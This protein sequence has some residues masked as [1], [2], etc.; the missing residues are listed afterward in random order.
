M[1]ELN[2]LAD[3]IQTMRDHNAQGAIDLVN[4]QLRDIFEELQVLIPDNDFL[5]CIDVFHNSSLL[6]EEKIE[7]ID[8]FLSQLT[9]KGKYLHFLQ[10]GA[11]E[12]DLSSLISKLWFHPYC[13]PGISTQFLWNS[14]NQLVTNKHITRIARNTDDLQFNN[15][16]EHRIINK[17]G[18]PFETRMQT[19]FISIKNKLPNSLYQILGE[20]D[21]SAKYFENFSFILHLLKNGKIIYDCTTKLLNLNPSEGY[22]LENEMRS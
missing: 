20:K 3:R 1:N 11:N 7:A 17:S 5:A 19:F 14:W 6:L 12:D 9:L 22:N 8:H 16:K 15:E 13:M 10:S 21:D 2:R 18:D 4:Q